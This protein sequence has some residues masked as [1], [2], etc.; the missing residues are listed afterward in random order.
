MKLFQLSTLSEEAEKPADLS[1]KIV[2][3]V[4]KKEKSE[5]APD[6]DVTVGP[7]PK[8]VDKP[9]DI[10]DKPGKSKRKS[11]KPAKSLLSFDDDEDD[12]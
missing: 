3:K 1:Q 9:L 8:P 11:Q 6:G 10:P 12:E 4:K 5:A 7:S 2:F